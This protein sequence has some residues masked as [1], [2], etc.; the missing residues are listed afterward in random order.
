MVVLTSWEQ[1]NWSLVAKRP[2]NGLTLSRKA[3]TFCSDKNAKCP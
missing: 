3:S 2:N 1:Q